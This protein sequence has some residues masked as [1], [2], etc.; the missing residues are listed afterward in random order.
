MSYRRDEKNPPLI[1]VLSLLV[2]GLGHFQLQDKKMGGILLGVA[3]VGWGLTMVTGFAIVIPLGVGGYAAFDAF[4]RAEVHNE[5]DFAAWLRSQDSTIKPG[6][7]EPAQVQIDVPEFAGGVAFDS[8]RRKAAQPDPVATVPVAEEA[9]AA[10]PQAKADEPGGMTIVQGT[11]EGTV[12][13]TGTASH[14]RSHLSDS[15]EDA[16]PSGGGGV[17]WV[18]FGKKKQSDELVDA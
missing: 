11:D 3:V 9:P 13:I 15:G 12:R 8:K 17:E 10:A 5:E 18:S 4:R 7:D 6:S 14:K 2:P 1:G 16:R